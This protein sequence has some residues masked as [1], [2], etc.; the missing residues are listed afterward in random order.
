LN[1]YSPS[2]AQLYPFVEENFFVIARQ[3]GRMKVVLRGTKVSRLCVIPLLMCSVYTITW[4][5]SESCECE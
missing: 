3:T 4:H 1:I 5:A 2:L